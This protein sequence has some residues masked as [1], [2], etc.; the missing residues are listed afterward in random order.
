MVLFAKPDRVERRNGD[1]R[2][3]AKTCARVF[4]WAAAELLNARDYREADLVA[5]C[6]P[7]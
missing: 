5:D 3:Q 1:K 4:L 2:R 7:S 6:T